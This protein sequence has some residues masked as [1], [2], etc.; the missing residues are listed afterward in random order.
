MRRDWWNEN[1][2]FKSDYSKP[3]NCSD[4]LKLFS[5]IFSIFGADSELFNFLFFSRSGFDNNPTFFEKLKENYKNENKKLKSI[6]D[7]I[8]K[9]LGHDFLRK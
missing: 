9:N 4:L 6:T 7:W 2:L 1:F 5:L 8:E 3:E